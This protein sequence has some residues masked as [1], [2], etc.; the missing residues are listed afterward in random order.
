MKV[1]TVTLV[2]LGAIGAF[3][4]PRMAEAL[5]P[6]QF[7]ILAGGE[8][9]ARLEQGV[10]INGVIH[11]FPVIS[12][13][14]EGHPADLILLSVKAS[15]L[16]QAIADIKNQM[17]GETQILP[18]LNGVESE[19]KVAAVYG[20]DH[21]LY[22]LMRLSSVRKQDDIVFENDRG[23]IHFG[24][25]CNENGYSER[26]RA[27]A[28]VFDLCRIPYAVDPDM[29]YSLWSKFMAN[30]GGNMVGALLD[31]PYGA[32]RVSDHASFLWR[33]AMLEV[34][35]IAHQKGIALK[36]EEIDKQEIRVKTYLNPLN[37]PSTLQD[38]RAGR[39]TEVDMFSGAVVRMGKEFGIPTPYN[40]F[41]YHGIKVMEEKI[42]KKWEDA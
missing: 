29:Q 30:I 26:V 7:R 24:E 5:G 40:E 23:E 10:R 18:L 21:V 38:L 4:A 32:Y 22:A 11:H 31:I 3:F 20:W 9:K 13:E 12:P 28:E 14:E 39:K 35:E 2:G 33:H 8:R 37:T 36:A 41:L 6:D 27:I 25:K 34:L 16:D 17:G 42:E 15:G 1:K 19:E